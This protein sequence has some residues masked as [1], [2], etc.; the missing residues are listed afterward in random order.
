M[1]RGDRRFQYVEAV[2]GEAG[3]TLIEL[4]VVIVVVGIL[5]AV[6]VFGLSGVT[7]QSAVSACYADAKSVEIAQEAYHLEHAAFAAQDQLTVAE[8]NGIRY[9]RSFPSN[10]QH[11]V[12]TTDTTGVVE[13]QAN[14]GNGNIVVAATDFD[15]TPNPCNAVK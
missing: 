1:S 3:F 10:D 15:G 2:E 13:V 14:D 11:Y 4:L 7:G 5:S 8:A 6:V 12:I 9:L